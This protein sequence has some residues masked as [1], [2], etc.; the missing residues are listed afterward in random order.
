M[1]LNRPKQTKPGFRVLAAVCLLV[2]VSAVTLCS[3]HCAFGFGAEPKGHSSVHGATASCC[4]HG[5]KASSTPGS[6][7]SSSCLAFKSALSGG[8]ALAV[9][10]PQLHFAYALAAVIIIDGTD[11]AQTLAP[12]SR[13]GQPNNWI[14]TPEVYLGAATFSLAP[15]FA[16]LV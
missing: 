11:S 2:W 7:A 4:H 10:Q 3:A 13:Q 8:K 16:S 12:P 14:A 15:P 1:T 5:N 9:V 6:S